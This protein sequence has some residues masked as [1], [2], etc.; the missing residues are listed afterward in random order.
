MM[1][2][3]MFLV[4][5]KVGAKHEFT[6]N[7]PASKSAAK[8]KLLF[9]KTASALLANN[10]AKKTCQGQTLQLIFSIASATKKKRFYGIDTRA[11][12]A[13]M[14]SFVTSYVEKGS[15]KYSDSG[16]IQ[17]YLSIFYA[18]YSC[19]SGE[20]QHLNLYKRR[21]KNCPVL[22]IRKIVC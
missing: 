1:K 14:S 6:F 4:T 17:G 5:P 18:L 20:R 10:S 21:R 19:I 22:V 11:T 13:S 2:I 15:F 3:M 9:N 8:H 16:H 7:K 12:A